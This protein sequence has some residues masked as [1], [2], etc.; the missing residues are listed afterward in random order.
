[1]ISTFE[2]TYSASTIIVTSSAPGQT[3]TEL[4]TITQPASTAT[5]INYITLAPVTTTFERTI[6][7]SAIQTFTEPTT[8]LGTTTEISREYALQ[9]STE[10]SI[11]PPVTMVCRLNEIGNS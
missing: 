11:V 3:A 6:T 5:I 7:T 8:V 2:T 4:L 1:M 9:I 10:T